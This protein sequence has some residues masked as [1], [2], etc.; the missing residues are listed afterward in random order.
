MRHDIQ[1]IFSGSSGKILSYFDPSCALSQLAIIPNTVGYYT[2]RFATAVKLTTS[3]APRI[4]IHSHDEENALSISQTQLTLLSFQYL[5]HSRSVL[6]ISA[7]LLIRDLN[8]NPMDRDNIH[9]DIMIT[10]WDSNDYYNL[11]R[12]QQ[13][14]HNQE[15]LSGQ[16]ILVRHAP[17]MWNPERQVDKL[18]VRLTDQGKHHAYYLGK[19]LKNFSIDYS[20]VSTLLRTQETLDAIQLGFDKILPREIASALDERNYGIFTGEKKWRANEELDD[21]I[22]KTI[23]SWDQPIPEGESRQMVYERICSFY[24]KTILPRLARGESVLYIGHSST[25]RCL[26]KYIECV[27]PPSL[28]DIEFEFDTIYVYKVNKQGYFSEKTFLFV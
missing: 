22:Q 14:P 13:L 2:I 3:K 9:L 20:Y 25:T 4:S 7:N 28:M 12:Q 18:D 11:Y 24:L 27:I 5:N 15:N 21:T 10:S 1:L 17:F 26:I 23:H 8:S 16:L 6:E 19:R